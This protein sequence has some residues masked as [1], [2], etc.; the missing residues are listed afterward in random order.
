MSQLVQ[1]SGVSKSTILYY[2]KEGLLP[3]P[4][5]PKPNVHLYDEK[6]IKILNFIKYLQEQMHYSIEEIKTIMIDNNFDFSKESD[7]LINYLIAISGSKQKAEIDEIK[8][9]CI[10]Y[11]IDDELLGEYYACA[12]K[13]AKLEYEMGAK[14]LANKN[15]KNNSLHALF[16]DII[17]TYKPYIFNQATIKEHQKRISK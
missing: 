16:F 4:S 13:L 17:L 10:I 8:K 2:I 1:D 3:E 5:K 15:N 12:N 11:D 9:L 6:Y 7:D 14:L